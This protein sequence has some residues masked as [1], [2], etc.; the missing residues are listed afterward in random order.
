MAPTK[1]YI[2][3]MVCARCKMVVK[4]E[5]E[6]L[7]I[8]PLQVELGEADLPNELTEDQKQQVEKA[9]K[10]VGFELITD[11]TSRLIEQIRQLLIDLVQNDNADKPRT[12]LSTWLEEKLHKD[13]SYLSS[14][15]SSV[16]GITIEQFYIQQK[17]EKVKELL[18]YDELTL[19]EIA[20]KLG[21][22][23]VA[24]LSNQFRKVTGLTPT[25][26]KQVKAVK[27]RSIDEL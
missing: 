20:F 16:E 9:L 13:Y 15:F 3:N 6:K 27:R 4:A 24:H 18:V 11:K 19:S 1:I 26:F 23:S 7:G 2:R 25:Y 22:S 14:L 17:I 5:L 21:Y 10:A 12:N 8:Q